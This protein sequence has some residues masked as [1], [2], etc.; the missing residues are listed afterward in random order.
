MA[1]LLMNPKYVAFISQNNLL[2]YEIL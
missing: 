2:A 1:T